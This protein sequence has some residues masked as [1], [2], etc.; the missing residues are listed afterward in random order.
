MRREYSRGSTT[1][2]RAS[3]G[4]ERRAAGKPVS[5]VTDNDPV[6]RIWVVGTSGSG[7]ST[8]ARA[9]HERTAVPWVQLDSLYHQP[10]WTPLPKS[11]FRAVVEQ[12]VAGDA[13]V[14]D[15]NYAAVGD[16]VLARADTVVLLDLPRH[17]ITRQIAWRTVRRIVTREELWNG[18]RERLRD[19]F[20]LDKERSIIVWAWATQGKARKRFVA[21]QAD[22]TH[23]A[24]R[25]VQLQSRRQINEFLA[26]LAGSTPNRH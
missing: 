11:E 3:F 22:P 26:N 8:L 14:V 5:R 18:N 15:G 21:A 12:M 9:I 10:H 17:V 24:L 19:L 25:F 4:L 7:K 23:Q 1:N 2:H 20:S 6:R 16:L 13:W